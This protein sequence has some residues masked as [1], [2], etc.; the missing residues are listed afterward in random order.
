MWSWD[1][2][3]LFSIA[4]AH[5]ES[6]VSCSNPDFTSI[7]I[8]RP[9][10]RH[11]VLG[12]TWRPLWHIVFAWTLSQNLEQWVMRKFWWKTWNTLLNITCECFSVHLFAIL[13]LCSCWLLVS[14]LLRGK[15]TPSYSQL[16]FSIPKT[17]VACRRHL[18]TVPQS[19]FRA[20]KLR[21]WFEHFTRCISGIFVIQTLGLWSLA[22]RHS[23]P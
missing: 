11:P 21:G 2:E 19:K 4:A 3:A 16:Q 5:Y 13:K 17:L 18:L 6:S 12:Q 10:A 8:F 1:H 15:I 9:S 22:T 7:F 20:V 23:L 14:S